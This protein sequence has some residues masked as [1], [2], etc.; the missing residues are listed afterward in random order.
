[1]PW[2][3]KF[4]GVQTIFFVLAVFIFCSCGSNA[5]SDKKPHPHRGILKPYDGK[6]IGYTI[7]NKE[8]ETL[9][10][11]KPIVYSDKSTGRGLVIQDVEALPTDC[12]KKI[13]DMKNY[14]KYVAQVKKVNVYRNV[15]FP[16]VKLHT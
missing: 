4:I 16:N 3:D 10:S 11:G 6:Q 15:V 1:M 14:D 13:M 9:N 8:A 12:M 2:F 7:T 5:S